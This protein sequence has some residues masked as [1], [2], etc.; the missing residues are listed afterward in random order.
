MKRILKRKA[1][2][3]ALGIIIFLVVSVIGGIG[4]Q[5]AKEKKQF[6]SHIASAEKYLSELDYEQAIAEYAAALEIEPNEQTVKDA[7]VETYLDY[8]QMYVS[9]GEYGEALNI[10]EQ[11]YKLLN[12]K[13]VVGDELKR[14]QKEVLDSI[15]EAIERNDLTGIYKIIEEK[16]ELMEYTYEQMRGRYCYD[17]KNLVLAGKNLKKA[18]YLCEFYAYLNGSISIKYYLGNMDLGADEEKQLLATEKGIGGWVYEDKSLLEGHS[19][20]NMQI[21]G[22]WKNGYLE[23]N[24]FWITRYN[25]L[26]E[27]HF[28]EGEYHDG[29]PDGIFKLE[30]YQNDDV[31]S[32]NF[33]ADNGKVLLDNNGNPLSASCGEITRSIGENYLKACG[34]N[35]ERY[36]SAHSLGKFILEE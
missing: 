9:E 19:E 4:I 32:W 17:G 13:V 1:V 28:L 16:K 24:A 3:I 10:L 8:A 11:A 15:W 34:Y 7:L 21:V 31:Y 29:N 30:I 25:D 6:A 26:N 5:S 36:S 14:E 12:E 2:L 27:T 33:R 35:K 20:A 23:G 18:L 22:T